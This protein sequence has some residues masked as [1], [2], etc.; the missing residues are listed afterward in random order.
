MARKRLGKRERAFRKMQIEHDARIASTHN[1]P[2]ITNDS[3]WWARHAGRVCQNVKYV[4]NG[5]KYKEIM[6]ELFATR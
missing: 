6:Q 4:D 2:A 5:N 1:I 3:G